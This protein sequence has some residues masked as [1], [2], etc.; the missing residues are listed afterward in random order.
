[1]KEQNSRRLSGRWQMMQ[2]DVVAIHRLE[3]FRGSSRLRPPT[4]E[5]APH[6]LRVRV[7]Q[8]PRRAVSILAGVIL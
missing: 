5:L 8:P 6:R 1:V 4:N 3:T 7:S 2:L